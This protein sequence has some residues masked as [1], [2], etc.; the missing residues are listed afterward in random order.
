MDTLNATARCTKCQND[1]Y[2]ENLD[3]L[4]ACSDFCSSDLQTNMNSGCLNLIRTY[5][6]TVEDITLITYKLQEQEVPLVQRI[7]APE[8]Q[9]VI[10]C[11]NCQDGSVC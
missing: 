7:P 9:R 5:S 11:I 2:P 4:G 6:E 1:W 3:A 8:K 10:N